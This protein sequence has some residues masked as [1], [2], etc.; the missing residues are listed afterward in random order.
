MNA[1]HW[2]TILS[3]EDRTAAA[4]LKR[5]ALACAEPFYGMAVGARNLLFD[6]R[7]RRARRLPRTTISVG[8]ITTGGTGKTPM[9]IDLARRLIA[10]QARPA[11]LLRGYHAAQGRSDEA[12]VLTHALGEDVTVVAN[13]DRFAGAQIALTRDPTITVF[14][15]DDGYQHRQVS[16]DLDLILIDATAPF[17]FDHL[18]PRG[19][20]REPVANLARARGVIVTRADQVTAEERTVLDRQIIQHSGRPPLAHAV[21]RWAG[22][23][24]AED[25]PVPVD[26]LRTRRVM[27]VTGIGNPEAFE[28]T[29]R[30]HTAGVVH[31]L[32]LDDHYDYANLAPIDGAVE[33]AGKSPTPPDAIVTTEKDWV[34]WKARR[35]AA[36]LLPVFRPVLGIHYLT[37]EES[38]DRLLRHTINVPNTTSPTT[39]APSS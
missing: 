14:I 11:I 22:F 25:Q 27:A 39:A 26:A 31:H 20:L 24:D 3:G 32:K 28:A 17:G 37:G 33:S 7:L 21:H 23:L 10:M 12:D 35:A 29:L 38:L 6:L 9:V 30:T 16:R 18:L 36:G 5:G 15:L 13:P 34:K 4:T 19:L 1:R 2:I 8:N